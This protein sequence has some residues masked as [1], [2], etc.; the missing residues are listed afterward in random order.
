MQENKTE[1]LDNDGEIQTRP[2]F[3]GEVEIIPPNTKKKGNPIGSDRG[4]VVRLEPVKMTQIPTKEFLEP[5]IA[6]TLGSIYASIDCLR[7]DSGVN[8]SR[9]KNVKSSYLIM[10][11][12]LAALLDALKPYS[13]HALT[14]SHRDARKVCRK[15]LERLEALKVMDA[16][17]MHNKHVIGFISVATAY[18]ETMHIVLHKGTKSHDRREALGLFGIG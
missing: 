18:L 6:Q 15:A 8:L 7:K 13:D 4:D 16:K 3:T 2:P 12:E 1:S 17:A 9:I 14:P 5:F 10:G 11:G